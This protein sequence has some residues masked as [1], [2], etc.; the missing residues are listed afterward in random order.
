MRRDDGDRVTLRER[1]HSV[2]HHCDMAPD[3]MAEG[4]RNLPSDEI[5][6]CSGHLGHTD[7]GMA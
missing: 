4:E 6:D 2:T 7:I 5:S 1:G 3:L